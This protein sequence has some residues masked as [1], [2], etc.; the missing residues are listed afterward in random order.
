MTPH[1]ISLNDCPAQPWRNGG[2]QTRELLAWP[3]PADWRLRISVADV[4]QS[5]P[6]SLYEGVQRHLAVWQG[7]G[8][9]LRMGAVG[10]TVAL[11]PASPPLE[12]SGEQTVSASLINGPVRDLNVMRRALPGGLL[13]AVA[14]QAWAPQRS[15]AG[16]FATQN[17]RCWAK[18]LK[19]SSAVSSWPLPAH[20]L[21]WFNPAPAELWWAPDE[22]ASAAARA[23]W[24]EADLKDDLP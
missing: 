9:H 24:L 14:H 19:V 7:A 6:F 3:G 11:T 15:A 8:L 13:G 22:P 5:G 16:V 12:F 17:G 20:T 18:P 4:A 2:G 10:E 21:C 1:F 23:W